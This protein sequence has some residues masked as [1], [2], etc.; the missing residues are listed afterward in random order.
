M[1]VVAISDDSQRL[2]FA[3]QACTEYGQLYARY[4]SR[5]LFLLAGFI[6]LLS[7]FAFW[8][9]SVATASLPYYLTP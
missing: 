5:S 6:V 9:F 1:G 7:L 2:L 8:Y 3:T 4:R